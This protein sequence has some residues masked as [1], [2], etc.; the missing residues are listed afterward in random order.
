VIFDLDSFKSINDTYGHP[1][2]DRVLEQF[3]RVA[4]GVLRRSD[5]VG[6]MGGEEFAAVLP[7]SGAAPAARVAERIRAAFVEACNGLEI[8]DLRPTLSGG[9]A[10]ITGGSATTLDELY[11][12]ADRALY[13]AKAEGRDRIIV[14]DEVEEDQSL[15]LMPEITAQ[16]A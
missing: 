15:M 6:R 8:A 9:V 16:A 5:V 14:A 13:R 7:G 4:R 10:A 2:G 11:A 3:G 12:A 1:V